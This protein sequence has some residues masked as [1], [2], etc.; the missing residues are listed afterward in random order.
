MAAD[1]LFEQGGPFSTRYRTLS[2]SDTIL[3][4][5]LS[6]MGDF[7][8][9]ETPV[10]TRYR[11]LRRELASR[12]RQVRLEQYGEEGVATLAETLGLPL[13]TWLSY[14]SGVII[15]GEVLLRFVM[16]TRVRSTWLLTG[17]G[18]RYVS[19]PHDFGTARN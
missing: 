19:P 18:P 4:F 7:C 1:P 8:M 17:K 13:R 9:D 14:E 5:E 6:L 15:P 10:C 3:R 2:G 12:I 16:A 11:A